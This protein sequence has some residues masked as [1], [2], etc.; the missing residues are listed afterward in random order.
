MTAALLKSLRDTVDLRHLRQI[1]LW[2]FQHKK[3]QTEGPVC[4]CPDLFGLASD[5]IGTQ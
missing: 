2:R 3:I 1:R 5:D 4:Q